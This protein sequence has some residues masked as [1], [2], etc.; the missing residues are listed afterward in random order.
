MYTGRRCAGGYRSCKDVGLLYGLMKS[1]EVRR[2]HN[3]A[4]TKNH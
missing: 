1:S 3:S 2:P 4:H